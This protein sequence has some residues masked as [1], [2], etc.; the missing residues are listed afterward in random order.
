M[1]YKH[2]AN[3]K[4][5]AVLAFS[6]VI[7]SSCAKKA[8]VQIPEVDDIDFVT[9]TY[10][11]VYFTPIAG[12]TFEVEFMPGFYTG[13]GGV[14]PLNIEDMDKGLIYEFKARTTNGEDFS[15]YSN[16]RK[17]LASANDEH[18]LDRIAMLEAVN[19]ARSQARVCGAT[20][21]PAVDPLVWD[22]RLEDAALI[23]TEDMHGNSF[24]DHTS[25]TDGSTPGARLQREGYQFSNMGENIAINSATDPQQ[26]VGQWLNSEGHCMNI[27]NAKFVDFG[28]AK[29]GNYWTQVFGLE[30]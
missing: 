18:D 5:I 16:T 13:S 8:A 24:F 29:K 11:Q 7:L 4:V 26:T 27:M 1:K 10:C 12:L 3:F 19:A 25:H 28:A 23:H 9:Q 17:V 15:A 2:F 21:M 20:S 30:Q 6:L 14:S 22:D